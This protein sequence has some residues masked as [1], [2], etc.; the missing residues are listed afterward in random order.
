MKD[1]QAQLHSKTVSLA[2]LEKAHNLV[3]DESA[4]QRSIIE[5]YESR[6]VQ[7]KAHLE[8]IN[9]DHSLQTDSL[10]KANESL[11]SQVTKQETLLNKAEEDKQAIAQKLRDTEWSKDQ[12]MK[13]LSKQVE[14]RR[15]EQE[16]YKIE[17]IRDIERIKEEVSL[18]FKEELAHKTAEALRMEHMYTERIDIL[19][20]ELTKLHV[21]LDQ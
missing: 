15:S 6:F 10:V 5:Q 11:K 16:S 2:Q 1:C 8:T 12:D 18:R 20:K 13:Q 17:S 14:D 19:Q 4:D 3:K 7:V 9:H 21:T